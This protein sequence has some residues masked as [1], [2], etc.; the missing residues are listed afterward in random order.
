MQR[1]RPAVR[2]R[3]L[4]ERAKAGRRSAQHARDVRR[5]RRRASASQVGGVGGSAAASS[6]SSQQQPLFLQPGGHGEGGGAEPYPSAPKAGIA[7]LLYAHDAALERRVAEWREMK[8][9]GAEVGWAGLG[10]EELE[11]KLAKLRAAHWQELFWRRGAW[12]SQ[13]SWSIRYGLGADHTPERAAAVWETWQRAS[14]G[15]AELPSAPLSTAE[16]AGFSPLVPAWFFVHDREVEARLRARLGSGGASPK[17]RLAINT[18]AELARLKREL[19]GQLEAMDVEIEAELAAE[20]DD[21]AALAAA[22]REEWRKRS[23]AAAAAAAQGAEEDEEDEA[24]GGGGAVVPD[25][26]MYAQLAADDADRARIEMEVYAGSDEC[27][28]WRKMERAT[29]N[30][31]RALAEREHASRGEC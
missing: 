3:A 19:W 1:P 25:F 24:S 8:P 12:K 23:A 29:A 4:S 5:R 6:S 10:G 26:P 31:L 20:T 17:S 16:E 2:Q 13:A 22:K 9:R 30:R 18:Q 11:A 7:A 14:K 21:A 27:L 28:Y 15:L